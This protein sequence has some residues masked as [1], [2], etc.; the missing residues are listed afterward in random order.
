MDNLARHIATLWGVGFLPRA[1][2]TW[3]SLVAALMGLV[4]LQ[5]GGQSHMRAA[6]LLAVLAGLWASNR[7]EVLVGSHDNKEIVIDEVAG[8]WISMLPLS[9]ISLGHGILLDVA[10]AFFLFRV[11]DI[12][13]PWPV[14]WI[15]RNV[16]GGLGV[17]LDDIVAGFM[18]A[19]ALIIVVM[20]SGNL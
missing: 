9:F 4:I 14:G 5:Y 3:G 7:Y 17:M 8:M 18:T 11:F 10:L 6:V 13:K 2:G 20:Y 12:W 15:D 1:P 19:L 16:K